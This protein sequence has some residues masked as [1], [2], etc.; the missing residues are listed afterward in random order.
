MF[1]PHRVDIM[2]PVLVPDGLGGHHKGLVARGKNISCHIVPRFSEEQEIQNRQSEVTTYEMFTD[3]NMVVY[4]G[5]I[6]RGR[7]KPYRDTEFDIMGIVNHGG[8]S[9]VWEVRLQEVR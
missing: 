9:R 7:N 6:I 4:A 5:D 8:L 2:K 3:S 1:K